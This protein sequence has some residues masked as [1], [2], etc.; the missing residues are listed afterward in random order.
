MG[1]IAQEYNVTYIKYSSQ[2]SRFKTIDQHH[3]SA[4]SAQIVSKNI[5]RQIQ[6][7]SSQILK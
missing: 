1:S 4:K 3:L 2:D 5:N 6:T 7:L